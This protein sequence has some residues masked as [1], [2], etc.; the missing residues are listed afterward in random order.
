MS[1]ND[2]TP[3][4]QEFLKSYFPSG[5][6]VAAKASVPKDN[7]DEAAKA[8]WMSQVSSL[9]EKISAAPEAFDTAKIDAAL[10]RAE[11]AFDRKFDTSKAKQT[12][13]TISSA[14]FKGLKSVSGESAVAGKRLKII[15][16]EFKALQKLSYPEKKRKDAAIR[17]DIE[18]AAKFIEGGDFTLADRA[19]DSA[20]ADIAGA[21]IGMDAKAAKDLK[22]AD[23]KVLL[24]T[25]DG[26]AQL[27]SIVANL[28]DTVPP[29]VMQS[30]LEARFGIGRR[31]VQDATDRENS[32][33][34]KAKHGAMLDTDS[35]KLKKYYKQL[36]DKQ[37]AVEDK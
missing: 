29:K 31:I 32:M 23:L 12:L 2:L 8:I 34:D 21:R 11:Q 18:K 26:R 30:I 20:E 24:K 14:F 16:K 22:P 10:D 28:D 37:N 13:K 15:V 33:M 6:K 36:M 4:Q 25:Q 5:P 7:V 9:R 3:Q 19:M 35:P 1:F 17:E 27:D